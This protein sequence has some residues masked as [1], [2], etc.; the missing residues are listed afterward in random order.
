MN[1][2]ILRILYKSRNNNQIL[3]DNYYKLYKENKKFSSY[4]TLIFI[5]SDE[6]S[7]AYLNPHTHVVAI[8]NNDGYIDN[9]IYL[10]DRYLKFFDSENIELKTKN[11]LEKYYNST[12][13]EFIES[14]YLNGF[15][16]YKIY[17]KL[18]DAVKK[19]NLL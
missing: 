5:C 2:S 14:L 15:I 13:I 12:K 11:I 1:N 7:K 10:Y 19:W 3:N 16:S 9:L 17:E 6:T 18:K 8:I 4:K